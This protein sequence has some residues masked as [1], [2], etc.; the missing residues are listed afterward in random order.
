[1]IFILRVWQVFMLGSFALEARPSGTKSTTRQGMSKRRKAKRRERKK[2][3]KYTSRDAIDNI[4]GVVGVGF[5]LLYV[6]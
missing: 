4:L 3:K 1:M 2:R 5:C 6:F